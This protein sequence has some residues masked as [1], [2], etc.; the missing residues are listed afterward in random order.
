MP[1]MGTGYMWSLPLWIYFS[2]S[3]I[4]EREVGWYLCVSHELPQEAHCSGKHFMEEEVGDVFPSTEGLLPWRGRW[5]SWLCARV[6]LPG[7]E[8]GAESHLTSAGSTLL[9]LISIDQ[10]LYWLPFLSTLIIS[11]NLAFN[12]KIL[13]C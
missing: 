13:V 7:R 9:I 2:E 6:G 1:A 5:W 4:K 8:A 3:D 12:Y 10:V 11:W